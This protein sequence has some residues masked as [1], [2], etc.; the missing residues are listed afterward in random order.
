MPSGGASTPSL[1]LLLSI[2]AGQL[3]YPHI[4]VL[5]GDG[6]NP[7][8]LGMSKI[9]SEDSVQRGLERIGAVNGAS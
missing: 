7:S 3:H 6:V 1:T 5:R 9:A 8:L 4:A 2:L